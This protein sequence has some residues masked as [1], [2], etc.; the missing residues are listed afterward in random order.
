MFRIKLNVGLSSFGK[1]K[2]QN[3]EIF[4]AHIH[5]VAGKYLT[6]T[7]KLQ[8]GSGHVKIFLNLA[9]MQFNLQWYLST[10]LHAQTYTAKIC[11]ALLV[12]DFI[13]L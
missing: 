8:N 11:S 12:L 10:T 5:S 13:Y 6:C 7:H 4:P 3:E 2:A 1:W 9:M